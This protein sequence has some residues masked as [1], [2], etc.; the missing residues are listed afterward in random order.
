[1]KRKGGRGKG[2]PS[3]SKESSLD[4][5]CGF[6][7]KELVKGRDNGARESLWSEA[8][9]IFRRCSNDSVNGICFISRSLFLGDDQD[10]LIGAPTGFNKMIYFVNTNRI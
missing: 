7:L 6:T 3:K 9:L 5:F 8:A 1:M 2:R 4:S 10:S